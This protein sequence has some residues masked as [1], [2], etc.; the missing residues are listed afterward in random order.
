MRRNARENRERILIAAESVFGEQ[1]A[2][3]STE[4]IAR[5]AGVGI[6]TVFRH[7]PTKDALVEAALLRHFADLTARAR[8][9]AE[10]PDPARAL[11]TLVRVMIETGATKIT[12]ASLLGQRGEFPASVGT[13]S[14]ELRDALGVVLHRAQDVG[15]ARRSITIDE[16][17]LLIRALAQ[18]SATMPTAQETLRRAVAIVLAGLSERPT[19]N[20]TGTL[21]D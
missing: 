19:T 9:L 6:G 14:S 8:A 12:L 15:A 13:A 7:F 4:D 5:R 1:G 18:A 11:R 17:Y 21:D 3:G 20:Q 16:V 2:V 10:D